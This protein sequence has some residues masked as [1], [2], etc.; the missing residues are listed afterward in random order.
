MC[1]EVLFRYLQSELQAFLFGKGSET[2]MS[3]LQDLRYITFRKIQAESLTFR[4]SE[5]K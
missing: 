1:I 4:F 5:V 2:Y 3:L